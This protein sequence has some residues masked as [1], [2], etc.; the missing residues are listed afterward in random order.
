[1]TATRVTGV[2]AVPGLVLL[3][4]QACG[5]EKHQRIGAAAGVAGTFVGIGAFSLYAFLVSGSPVA[6]YTS[7]TRWGYEPGGNP[8]GTTVG[9]VR[10]LLTQ[11]Y[12]F[13]ATGPMAPYDTLNAFAALGAL[14]LAPLIWR[15]LN[16]GYALIV[17]TAVL[18]PLSS[19]QFEGLG[20]YTSVLFPMP[21]VLA[22]FAGE[23]RHHM[24]LAA[25]AVLYALGL[26]MFVTVH[27]LF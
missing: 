22:S 24:L 11:P 19:G 17:I 13:L 23:L 27:P 25:S 18:L 1:M 16:A 20:R 12:Q 15:R 5:R 10:A 7:I 8:F 2:M 6:W 4:W 14:A 3:A 26:A 9:L 21:I